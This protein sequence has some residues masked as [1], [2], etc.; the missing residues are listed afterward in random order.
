M[1]PNQKVTQSF[2]RPL[3]KECSFAPLLKTF[4][5]LSAPSPGPPPRPN[6]ARIQIPYKTPKK[7]SFCV[8][9][10]Q[11]SFFAV[12]HRFC[13]R[14][15]SVTQSHPALKHE[16]TYISLPLP[17]RMSYRACRGT[18]PCLAVRLNNHRTELGFHWQR[19]RER[20]RGYWGGRTWA[21]WHFEQ[22]CEHVVCHNSALSDVLNA[23]QPATKVPRTPTSFKNYPWHSS[24][25]RISSDC[26]DTPTT[27]ATN[28]RVNL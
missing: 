1:K 24:L 16:N 20:E 12:I 5:F 22:F 28:A 7:P 27:N 11:I 26:T 18:L 21:M 10:I 6:P 15:S 3:V 4:S 13:S 25:S 23:Y 2:V 17:P 14:L 9:S 8:F 19:E